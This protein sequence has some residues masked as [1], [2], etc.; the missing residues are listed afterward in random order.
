MKKLKFLTMAA[1]AVLCFSACQEEEPATRQITDPV[2]PILKDVEMPVEAN[3]YPGTNVRILGVGFSEGDVVTCTSLDGE[4]A[5]TPEVV[6]VDNNSITIAVPE[7]SCGRYQVTVTREG[8]TSTLPGELSIPYI[9]V[10]RKVEVP[11]NVLKPGET[12][13]ITAKDDFVAGDKVRFESTSYPKGVALE[14]EGTVS[15]N[16]LTVKVPADAYSVNSLT[17]VR[18]KMI[19]EIGQVRIG[20]DKFTVGAGGIV[21]YTSDEGVHGLVAYPKATMGTN[22]DFEGQSYGPSIPNTYSIGVNYAVYSG[23]T[24]S[25]ALYANEQKAR[26]AGFAFDAK[27]ACELAEELTYEQNGITYDDYFLPSLDE[28]VQLWNVLNEVNAT[29]AWQPNGWIPSGNY[30][31]STEYDSSGGWVW[32]MCY[33]NFYENPANGGNVV[34]G[35]A[36]RVG[37]KISAIAVRQF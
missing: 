13:T 26:D 15:G 11:T 25:A 16:T 31:S 1:L 10:L 29:G 18:G 35:V 36:D 5:F 14:A 3:A 28:L 32:A 2:A 22:G 34:T 27:T 37:W 6:N 4:P 21:F 20:L 7:T 19:G 17:L 24:N 12:L 8:L 33:C 23:K 30:W 9:V